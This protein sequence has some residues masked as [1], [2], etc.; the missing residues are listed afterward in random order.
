MFVGHYAVGL[1]GKRLVPGVSLGT[2]VLAAQLADTL[3][4][5]LLLLGV[6]HVRIVPGL[7]AVSPLDFTDYPVSHSL[8][9]QAGWGLLVGGAHWVVRR[10][11]RAAAVLAA[12]VLSHWGLDLVS[13]R[14]DLPV[15]P[16]GPLLGLGLWR[17]RAATLAVE[18]ALYGLGVWAYLTG[19][20]ARDRTGSAAAWALVGLLGLLWLA[21]LWGPPPPSERAV[22]LSGVLLW[23]AI[24]WAA[25]VDR[26][27]VPARRG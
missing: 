12:V 18:G 15:L 8:A 1:A 13:H 9:A 14:P 25:W 4:P 10:D 11:G 27:R 22:A 19:T 3:W 26:H 21:S 24:P 17:S 20:R 7:T 2:L 16:G 23:G 6:E 5:A